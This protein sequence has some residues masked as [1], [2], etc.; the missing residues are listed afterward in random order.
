MAS[1]APARDRNTQQ[2]LAIARKNSGR[3]TKIAILGISV[4][5]ESRNVLQT[6]AR[7]TKHMI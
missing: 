7:P 6:A 2:T 4:V 1:T 3:A 5:A